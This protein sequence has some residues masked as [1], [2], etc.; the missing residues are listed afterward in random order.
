LHVKG[1]FYYLLRSVGSTILLNLYNPVVRRHSSL[2][3]PIFM[4]PPFPCVVYDHTRIASYRRW[5]VRSI[6]IDTLEYQQTEKIETELKDVDRIRANRCM[7]LCP[8]SPSGA[9]HSHNTVYYSFPADSPPSRKEAPRWRVLYRI[10]R[11]LLH[12]ARYGSFS[13]KIETASC[14]KPANPKC[15]MLL[16]RISCELAGCVH[17]PIVHD[18]RLRPNKP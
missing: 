14:A 4:V 17:Q 1:G 3:P 13:Q 9:S 6:E 15:F 16:C 12:R 2:R 5:C 8:G 11:Q 10:T 18:S 7:Q